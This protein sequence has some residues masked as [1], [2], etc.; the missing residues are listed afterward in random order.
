[1]LLS[2]LPL[3]GELL[4]CQIRGQPILGLLDG[5]RQFGAGKQL[6]HPGLAIVKQC[7][8]LPGGDRTTFAND[9]LR[10]HTTLAG[11]NI[12]GID[13]HHDQVINDK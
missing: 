12:H 2:Q 3:F 6:L 8:F 5:D 13:H 9:D 7:E 4:F 11:R 1:M 10:N